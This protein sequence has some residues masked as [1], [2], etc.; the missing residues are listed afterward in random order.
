METN[1]DPA[2]QLRQLQNAQDAAAVEAWVPPTPLWH[3]PLLATLIVALPVALGGPSGLRLPAF[4]VG[5]VVAAFGVWDANR[6]RTARPRSM[7]K[8]VRVLAFYVVIVTTSI[9]IARFTG[10]AV[11]EISE[12]WAERREV[13]ALALVGVW[14]LATA[15]FA[16]G[17][18]ATNTWRDRWV[19]SAQ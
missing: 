16:I 4:V 13:A 14:L 7:R 3:A 12:A 19:K 9:V 8:P 10:G 5:A 1:I 18:H 11:T 6:R 17:V 15:A 2:D